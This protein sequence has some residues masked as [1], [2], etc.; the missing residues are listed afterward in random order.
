MGASLSCISINSEVSE[1][2]TLANGIL[3]VRVEGG[4][5][6]LKMTMDNSNLVETKTDEPS[7]VESRVQVESPRGG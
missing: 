1:C 5:Q 3:N 4:Q 6:L 7:K 2:V